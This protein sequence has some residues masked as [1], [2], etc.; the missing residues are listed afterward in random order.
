MEDFR[1]EL[2]KILKTHVIEGLEAVKS[3]SVTDRNYGE[4]IINVM[5]ADKTAK[6]LQSEIDFDKAQAELSDIN[7]TEGE[8]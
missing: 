8:N 2:I 5:N 3:L 4:A 1:I 6:Q 7:I